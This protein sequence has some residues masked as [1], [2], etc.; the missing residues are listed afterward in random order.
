MVKKSKKNKVKNKYIV[1]ILLIIL[2]I[3]G[4]LTTGIVAD[5]IKN[6]SI[7]F[8]G[9]FYIPFLIGIGI[10]GFYLL[11]TKKMPLIN[12][13]FLGCFLIL[14]AILNLPKVSLISDFTLENVFAMNIESFQNTS[15]IYGNLFALLIYN[16]FDEVGSIIIYIIFIIIGLI[17]ILEKSFIDILSKNK[18]VKRPKIATINK[19]K[20]FIDEHDD[21]NMSNS[22]DGIFNYEDYLTKQMN[23]VSIMDNIDNK[24]DKKSFNSP[25]TPLSRS[26]KNKYIHNSTQDV[27]IITGSTSIKKETSLDDLIYIN[28]Q[29]K[30]P[31][32]SLL[33]EINEKSKIS[34]GE[35]KET[36]VNLM[37]T[38]EVYGISAEIKRA[39]VGPTVT[40]F[41][42][43]IK[44]GTKLNKLTS[45]TKELALSLAAKDVRIEAPIPGTNHVGIEIPNKT[46][47]TICFKDVMA[48]IPSSAGI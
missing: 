22:K 36:M 44:A 25:S 17:L 7:F 43:E 40:Q 12:S 23:V 46:R 1:S 20:M 39:N 28:D 16:L 34:S 2:P 8:V 19:N 33:K 48:K 15:G 35:I 31:P 11:I 27:P 3:L 21:F 4:L 37:K 41:E 38:L 30:L 29:Y 45:I 10:C 9:W 47:T 5:I 18:A 6:I 14:M 42:L 32:L 24:T 26:E 13:K